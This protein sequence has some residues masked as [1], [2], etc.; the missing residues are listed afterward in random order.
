MLNG[1]YKSIYGLNFICK[2]PLWLVVIK[3][4]SRLYLPWPEI[5]S[6]YT[7]YTNAKWVMLSKFYSW[8]LQCKTMDDYRCFRV[9]SETW[10]KNSEE[11]QQGCHC[12]CLKS[13]WGVW[14]LCCLMAPGL[15]KDIR[16]HVWAYSSLCLQI[17]GPDIRPRARV[18]G[19]STW[20]FQMATSSQAFV[21]VCVDYH[22]RVNHL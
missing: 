22:L 9:A 5:S 4:C 7:A 20:W 13:T 17:T 10:C 11:T 14:D 15:S 18:N 21:L 3:A 1:N 8:M 19:L 12:F 2:W 16:C 6:N